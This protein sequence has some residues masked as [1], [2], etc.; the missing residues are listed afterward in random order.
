MNVLN[1]GGGGSRDLPSIY[2]GWEQTLLDVDPTVQPD[3]VCDAKKLG[4][5]PAARYDAVFCSH[6]LEHFYQHEV[7][8]VLGG[9]RHVLK[10]RGFAHVSVPDLGELFTAIVRDKRDIGETWY[11]CPGG[12][13][14]FH[15][16]LYGWG[17]QVAQGNVFYAHRTGF[18][19]KSL[20]KSLRAAK[21]ASVM[22]ACDG[23]N[24][25]AFAFKVKPNKEQRRRLG[26]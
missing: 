22:T 11:T 21:F 18:T 15:D 26:I 3:I 8:A 2:R 19:Q 9:F 20:A 1:V 4:S 5:L 25:H 16:V 23:G 24:L 13:I 12:P 7:P 6:T 14:T 10:P 17:R